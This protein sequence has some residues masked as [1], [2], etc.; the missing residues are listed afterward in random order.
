MAE[1]KK[2]FGRRSAVDIYKAIAMSYDETE[3]EAPRV[4]AKGAGEL[5]ERIVTS[6]EKHNIPLY[7]DPD[8]AALLFQLDLD[9]QIPVSLYE[10]VAEVFAF[11]YRLNREEKELN[12]D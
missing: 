3:E 4:R 9:R 12:K 7:E 2:D 1:E 10:A 11:L 5:A 6:A 8:L